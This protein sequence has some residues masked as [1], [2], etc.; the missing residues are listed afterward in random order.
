MKGKNTCHGGVGLSVGWNIPISTLL[1]KKLLEIVDCNNH[2]KAAAKYFNKMC[3]PDSLNTQFNPTGDNPTSTCELCTGKIGTTYCTNQDP[4]AGSIGA[5]NC[6]QYGGGDVAFVS[7]TSIYEFVALNHTGGENNE[8]LTLDDF[9]LLCPNYQGSV[10]NSY[11]ATVYP[12]ATAPISD[13]EKCNWG[14][15]PGRAVITSSRKALIQRQ[16]YRNFLKASVQLFYNNASLNN[17]SNGT[18]DATTTTTSTSANFFATTLSSTTTTTTTTAGMDYLTTTAMPPIYFNLFASS[19]FNGRDLLFLD[20]TV[21][22]KD[23]SDD[24]TFMSF[25]RKMFIY[26]LIYKI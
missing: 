1:E 15:V 19:M 14:I 25:L 17:G 9:E 2:V 10:Y 26:Y 8:S 3:A 16:S 23:L 18:G 5:M 7:L 20:Q 11:N 13:Y 12:T 6:L 22:F 24:V 4:Y 21:S